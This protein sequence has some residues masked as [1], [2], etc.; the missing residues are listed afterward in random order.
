MEVD[1]YEASE[2][3]EQELNSY[4]F[5]ISNHPSSKYIAKDI[6][7]LSQIKKFF[8]KF[9]KCI[10]IINN[11]HEI[12]T[13]K[14]DKMCF[15]ECSDET[16]SLEFVLF[17]KNI[18]MIKDIKKNDLVEINGTVARRYDKYQINVNKISKM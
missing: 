7:K 15:L 18:N 12:K 8:N 6:V 2:L 5:Y 1:E 11:V 9:V 14:G 3:M 10:V 16:S 4:G 13:K 17:P